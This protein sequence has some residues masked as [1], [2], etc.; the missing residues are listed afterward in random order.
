[1]GNVVSV[2]GLTH[3]GALADYFAHRTLLTLGESLIGV[4]IPIYLLKSGFTLNQVLLFYAVNSAVAV[5]GIALAVW[6]SHRLAPNSLLFA[7]PLSYAVLIAAFE[8]GVGFPLLVVASAVAG[9][10]SELYWVI[11]NIDLFESLDSGSEGREL[12]LLDLLQQVVASAA[13]YLGGALIVLVGYGNLFYIAIGIMAASVIPTL[14]IRPQKDGWRFRFRISDFK[15]YST[16]LPAMLVPTVPVTISAMILW[17][18]FVQGITSSESS[19]GFIITVTGVSTLLT[20]VA[21]RKFIDS[22]NRALL[23]VSSLVYGAIWLVRAV[24]TDIAHIIIMSVLIGIS[25]KAFFLNS[26]SA[27]SKYAKKGKTF[28][29]VVFREVAING[30]RAVAYLALMAVPD[31]LK[32]PLSF[33]LTGLMVLAMGVHTLERF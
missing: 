4:F 6:L 8:A 3:R 22:R 28:D 17:P 18:V 20:T 26:F 19:T 32:I 23:A 12:S 16:I 2:H 15:K 1:M 11:Y 9:V 14:F 29:F 13:P 7:S 24:P 33:A 21:L 25:G 10:L 30:T 27:V 31:G 5:P